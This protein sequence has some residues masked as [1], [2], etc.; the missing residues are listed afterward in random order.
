[1]LPINL[2]RVYYT[3]MQMKFS[4]LHMAARTGNVD[5]ATLLLKKGA[6]PNIE[7]IDG[8]NPSYW[9]QEKGYRAILDLKGM[10]DPKSMTVDERWEKIQQLK[11]SRNPPKEEP[12]EGKKKGK[13][14][15]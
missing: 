5:L 13:K 14:K 12:E 8:N 10:P 3:C 1:M 4:A 7:D 15:K 2:T 6:D 11:L 9:A